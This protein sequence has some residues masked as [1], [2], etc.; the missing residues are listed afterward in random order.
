[1]LR[2]P[3]SDRSGRRR[4]VGNRPHAVGLDGGVTT[5]F[6]DLLGMDFA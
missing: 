2:D 6:Q 5:N 4:P 1:V 3:T